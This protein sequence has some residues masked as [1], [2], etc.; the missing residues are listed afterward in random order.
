MECDDIT[1]KTKLILTR[2]E[3]TF[4]EIRF[5]EKPYLNTFFQIRSLLGL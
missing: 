3:L 5:K 2:F 4:G 1:M